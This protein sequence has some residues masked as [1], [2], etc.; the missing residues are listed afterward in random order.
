MKTCLSRMRTALVAALTA[1]LALAA[2]SDG[3]SGNAEKP[4]TLRVLA[5][6]TPAL[7]QEFYEQLA[8]TFESQNPGIEVKIENSGGR[9]L[10]EYFRTLAASKNLPDVATNI[11]PEATDVELFADLTDQEWAQRSPAADEHKFDGRLYVAWPAVQMQS[12]VFFNKT[13]FKQAGITETP[14]TLGEMTQ[15][16]QKLK[17]SGT[18]PVLTNGESLGSRIMSMAY[19]SVFTGDREWYASRNAGSTTFAGS[20]WADALTAYKSWIDKGF[21]PKDA[22]GRKYAQS[23]ADFLKGDAAMWLDGGWFA[24]TETDTPHDFEVGV[25][26]MPPSEGASSMAVNRANAWAVMKSSPQ[27]EAAMKWVKYATTDKVAV[28]AQIEADGSFSSTVSYKQSP[29]QREMQKILDSAELTTCCAGA[30]SNSPPGGFVPEV[31]KQAAKLHTGGTVEDVVRALDSWWDE[32][33]Q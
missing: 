12:L 27:R 26:A 5:N 11:V 19:P 23:Q 22:L 33:K 6:I 21:V 2:C 3:G 14:A 4:V 31:N 17:D 32:N 7:S 20:G 29:L 10:P 9:P 30:G 8:E 13:L 16:M 15:A 28:R 24:A 1:A 25:F 18:L